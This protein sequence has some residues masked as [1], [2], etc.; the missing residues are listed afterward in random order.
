MRMIRGVGID[1]VTVSDMERRVERMTEGALARMF[2]PAEIE[3]SLA[4]G[5][6]RGEYLAARF[7]GKEAV[8]KA[9]APC[10][11]RGKLELRRIEIL[12]REDGSP[13]A[14]EEE[15]S[16]AAAMRDAGV[17][18]IHLSITT[19]GDTAAAFVVAE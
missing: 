7:A 19:E 6:R 5:N 17:S 12:N 1:M 8:Y 4:R 9:L 14:N 16:L 3:A 18:R 2:T 10:L 15:P 11:G 13:Y